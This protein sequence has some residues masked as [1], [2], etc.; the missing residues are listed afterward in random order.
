MS[1]TIGH[2]LLHQTLLH[3]TVLEQQTKINS[4]SISGNSFFLPKS[5]ANQAKSQIQ[6]SPLSTK[7][8]SKRTNVKTT[9][10]P[11]GTQGPVSVVP[12]AVL[13]S[14]PASEVIYASSG[15]HFRCVHET[16][17]NHLFTLRFFMK[18]LDSVFFSMRQLKL[19]NTEA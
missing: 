7:F 17:R 15:R 5:T 19:Q 4:C 13:A 16:W 6:K 14:E 2:S 11:M 8:H 10:L 9:K 1:N 18:S 12:R 3:P